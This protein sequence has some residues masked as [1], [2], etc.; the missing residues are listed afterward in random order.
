MQTT[1]DYAKNYVS[2]GLSVIPV[3]PRGKNPIIEWLPYQKRRP[4]MEEIE[5]WWRE[6]PDANIAIVTGG[7]SGLAVV[8]L[9][10]EK[11]IAFAKDNHFPKTPAVKTGKGYHLYYAYKEGVGNF[12]RRADLP[13]IDLRGEGGYVVAPPSVHA[14]GCRYEWI[15]GKGFDD[16]TLAAL[17]EIV[18]AKSAADKTPI[19]ELYHGV[20]E[21]QR[22]EALARIVGSLVSD[23]LTHDQCL[24]FAHAWNKQNIPPLPDREVVTTVLS[25]YNKHQ[26]EST[27]VIVAP[28]PEDILSCVNNIDSLERTTKET[29]WLVYGLFPR[30][31]VSIIA[32]A[33]KEGKT[34]IA[35]EIA[36]ALSCGRDVFGLYPSKTSKVLFIEGD[37]PNN[38][39]QWRLKNANYECDEG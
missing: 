16:L 25:I 18:L 38:L 20:P 24:S 29:D 23:G 1:L 15:T 21:G 11:A 7:I 31:A 3:K 17:P 5:I 13:D 32:G 30:K 35:L 36:T 37:I 2:K 6:N 26:R 33:Q 10:S 12:Q 22:N 28:Q 4:S 9:D 19:K 14:S 34:W 39:I 27:A 8:D